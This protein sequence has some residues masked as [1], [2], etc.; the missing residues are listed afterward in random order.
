MIRNYSFVKEE[1]FLF[2]SFENLNMLLIIES[3]HFMPGSGV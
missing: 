1:Q 3:K 2:V